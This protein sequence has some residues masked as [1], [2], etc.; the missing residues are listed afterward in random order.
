MTGDGIAAA[1]DGLLDGLVADEPA[2]DSVAV[3][4]TDVLMDSA[5]SR[6][7]VAEQT[8]SFALTLCPLTL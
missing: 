6:R 4:E 8:L 7:R 3:L 5:V 1:Y 2:A